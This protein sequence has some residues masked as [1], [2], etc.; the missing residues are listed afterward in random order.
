MSLQE[1]EKQWEVADARLPRG[2][3]GCVS[4]AFKALLFQSVHTWQRWCRCHTAL[5]M[6]P[7]PDWRRWRRC[8][9]CLSD[10]GLGGDRRGPNPSGL[11]GPVPAAQSNR[12]RHNPEPENLNDPFQTAENGAG[13]HLLMRL[14]RCI[15]VAQTP[16][17]CVCMC[18]CVSCSS[19]KLQRYL[20]ANPTLIL[21][22]A[23]TSVGSC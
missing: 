7:G 15:P 4:A 13:I 19:L 20:C 14:S 8:W 1:K 3:R 18:V 6:F 16:K 10:T 22:S 5:F 21:S 11:C 12:P 17:L 9:L 23:G 2:F